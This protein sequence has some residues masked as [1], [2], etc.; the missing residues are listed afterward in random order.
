MGRPRLHAF[1]IALQLLLRFT[2]R[3]SLVAAETL[4]KEQ[5]AIASQTSSHK[6]LVRSERG[7]E[8]ANAEEAFSATPFVVDADPATLRWQPKTISVILPCAEEREYAVK[9][10]EAVFNSTP[11][12]VLREIV[13][14]DDGSQPPLA[15]SHLHESFR[16]QY[17]VR[18]LRH[19]Q[20][21]GLIGAKKTGGDAARGDILV[22]FDCHVAPQ[23][24][25]YKSF[26]RLIG[27]NYR[28]VVVPQITSLDIDTWTQHRGSSGMSKCYLTWDCDFKWF[29]SDDPYI[30]VISGGLL[31]MSRQWFKETG[32]YDEQM[33]GW[34]GENL[35]QSLRTWLC[36][37]EIMN[38]ADSQ[39]AHMWRVASDKRTVSRYQ[40]VGDSG[41]NRAR[42]VYAWYGEFAEK[43]NH[44]RS[45]VRED[46]NGEPWYGN[47][48]NILDVKKR[49]GCRPF[50]WFL[51]RFRHIYE[52]AGLIPK[53]VFML[54]DAST[55]KCLRY[56]GDEGTAGNGWGAAKL[57]KCDPSKGSNFWH[58]ANPNR[59]GTCCAGLRAWNTDQCIVE[60][61][62]NQVT[63]S[64][65]DVS[66]RN[67]GQAYKL[68]SSGQLR[69]HDTCLDVQDAKLVSQPC[70]STRTRWE[71]MA[72]QEPL[73]TTLYHQA[74]TEHPEVFSL[75]DRQLAEIGGPAENEA[76]AC[77]EVHGGC[78]Q[79]FAH[80][81]TS[82][83][84]ARTCLDEDLQLSSDLNGCMTFLFQDSTL[85][86]I[87]DRAVCL[88][89]WNDQDPLT[90]GTYSC[91]AGETQ[92]F[93][94]TQKDSKD[95]FCNA[96][97][98]C[99]ATKA[100]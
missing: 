98:E 100:I 3:S 15:Q 99:F 96:H 73:E 80:E 27:E 77:G 50:P 61:G 75:L 71:K 45:F 31:G 84:G 62:K 52:D 2:G 86:P 18:V 9:T 83:A 28:R 53:E 34:G 25:W 48:S 63:T 88:D 16:R 46:V 38:A 1:H 65:C 42:A 30:A 72:A 22:F 14:V 47:I 64:V 58:V 24:D 56:L 69:I 79:L 94:K 51:R 23:K 17:N 12:D 44:F 37:G 85:R 60:F 82:H 70:S 5:E 19:E 91:H 59:R 95:V 21:V 90:W 33:M 89:R 55:G 57:S 4:P 87:T 92:R 81:E 39:V 78:F 97:N 49:L 8:D 6:R 93:E 35:D 10:V 36:G 29:D 41:R 67:L 74:R 11:R 54:R 32:G 68:S 26:I 43:L 13:V 40:H 76:R 20:T 66:G 7:G